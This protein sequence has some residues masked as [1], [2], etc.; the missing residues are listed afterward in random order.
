MPRICA[1][2]IG[3]IFDVIGVDADVDGVDVLQGRRTAAAA[4]DAVVSVI[5]GFFALLQLQKNQNK[6]AVESFPQRR[7]DRRN[8]ARWQERRCVAPP[9]VPRERYRRS[10]LERGDRAPFERVP[11]PAGVGGGSGVLRING[12]S[13]EGKRLNVIVVSYFCSLS[14]C[15]FDRGCPLPNPMELLKLK[16]YFDRGNCDLTLRNIFGFSF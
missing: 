7:Y 11:P 4:A 6:E 16:R 10:Y 1:R 3:F 13:E 14:N 2:S 8:G 12:A 15:V 9:K 5:F